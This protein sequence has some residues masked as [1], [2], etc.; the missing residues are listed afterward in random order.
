MR[1]TEQAKQFDVVVLGAGLSGCVTAAILARQGFSV[2][3][4][5]R[6]THPRFTIGESTTTVT[7][8]AFLR[9]A[10]RFGVPEL[11][12]LS[13]S[14][15][16]REKLGPQHGIKR[17]FGFVYHQPE[18][19]FVLAE[20]HQIGVVDGPRGAENHLFRQDV[21]AHLFRVA[22]K[23]GAHPLLQAEP[24]GVDLDDGGATVRFAQHGEVRARFVVDGAG[25]LAKSHQ[26]REEP[27]RVATR[28]RSIVTHLLGVKPFDKCMGSNPMTA[29]FAS[30]T[31]H[32]VFDGGWFWVIPFDNQPRSLNP[33]CSVGLTLDLDRHPASELP[34]EEEFHRFVAQYPAIARQL[35]D[36]VAVRPWVK[37][38]KLQYSA[39]RIAGDR[40][41]LMNAAAC[42][43]D[44]LFSRGLANTL[45]TIDL[46]IDPLVRCLREDAFSEQA[47]EAVQRG[48]EAD[49][50]VADRFVRNAYRSFSDF[51]L[52]D[53]WLRIWAIERF[54]LDSL[55]DELSLG[56]IAW[57]WKRAE[58]PLSHACEEP[59]F[60]EA[61]ESSE[62]L[63]Q[64]VTAGELSAPEAG[65]RIRAR[66]AELP[67][68]L[69]GVPISAPELRRAIPWA[70]TH[71]GSRCLMAHPDNFNRWLSRKSDP[72]LQ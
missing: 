1:R 49:L 31:L 67:W 17:V 60:R 71:Y 42:F 16:V 72:W 22:L 13:G 46:L 64:A 53:A 40:Y 33:L 4:T 38:G 69:S 25:F 23:H 62:R 39:A 3:L 52:W 57:E 14:N 43:V 70:L 19:D 18:R 51:S 63:V 32:H 41:C 9:L 48:Y 36:A 29:S 45:R 12:D 7:S 47:F 26:L 21:D 15:Q 54:T 6:G 65:N 34:A 35:E 44:P 20:S 27:T 56:R 61:F 10:E 28:S 24:L 8:L 30:G 37:T 68:E 55:L 5:D 2:L 66:L 58:N 59:S 11:A 50:S